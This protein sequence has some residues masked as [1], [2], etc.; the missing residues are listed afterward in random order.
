MEQHVSTSSLRQP[1][2]TIQGTKMNNL[3]GHKKISLHL[4]NKSRIL[5][6]YLS[7]SLLKLNCSNKFKVLILTM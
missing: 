2:K 7:V 1:F 3:I 5:L 6:Q 4:T